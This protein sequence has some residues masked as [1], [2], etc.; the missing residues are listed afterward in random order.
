MPN[1]GISSLINLILAGNCG[2]SVEAYAFSRLI[3]H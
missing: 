1:A 2:D 3:Q